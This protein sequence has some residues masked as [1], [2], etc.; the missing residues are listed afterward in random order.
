M[1]QLSTFAV[2]KYLF[3]VD[4][5]QVGMA[6]QLVTNGLKVAEY[7]PDNAEE[8]VDMRHAGEVGI[9]LQL[10]GEEGQRAKDDQ[11]G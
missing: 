10:P 9:H 8:E 11:P 2:G 1:S 3:G 7:R 6:V 4:V 5:S